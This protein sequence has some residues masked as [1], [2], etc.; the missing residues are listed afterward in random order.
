MKTIS[1]RQAGMFA[2]IETRQYSLEEETL[3]SEVSEGDASW[4]PELAHY[5]LKS[6]ELY[7]DS[8]AEC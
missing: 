2:I 8:T 6:C 7:S 4:S 1:I 3:L 5:S